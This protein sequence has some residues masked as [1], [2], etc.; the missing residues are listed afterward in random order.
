MSKNVVDSILEL[1]SDKI[2]ITATRRQIDFNGGYVNG[3]TTESFFDYV[4]GNNIVVERD[5]GGSNQGTVNDDGYKSFDNDSTYFKLFHIDPW[6]VHQEINDGVLE[7]IKFIRFILER[8]PFARFEIGTEEDIRR[9][10]VNETDYMLR[11]LEHG[12]TDEEFQKIEYV[13]IQSGESLDLVN[14]K[15]KGT[16]NEDRFKEMINICNKWNKKSKEHNGDF[17][18]NDEYKYRFDNGLTSIN[19]GPEM[20]VF[21]TGIY[22]DYMSKNEIDNFYNVC[23]ESNKWKRWVDGNVR[24]LSKKQLIEICG[25]YNY[26]S[27]RLPE[28]NDL[29]KDK[30]KNKLNSLLNIVDGR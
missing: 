20:A 18:S 22:L 29:V 10:S 13:V 28:I 5:H 15:N 27:I 19:I 23:L 3:W 30:I 8:N 16:F 14:R 24:D 21:E 12:L 7:T 25:H 9:F 26:G 11:A 6:K 4:Y 17:L 2:G 1:G